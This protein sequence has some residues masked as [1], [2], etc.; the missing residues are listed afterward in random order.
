M[1]VQIADVVKPLFSV[2]KMKAAGN[3]GVFGSDEGDYIMNK[4]TGLKTKILDNGSDFTMRVRVPKGT[5]RQSER[6]VNM[7]GCYNGV[8]AEGCNHGGM[9]TAIAEDEE[10]TFQRQ[11]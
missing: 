6:G 11:P 4:A 5:T 8:C 10:E 1:G 9:W 3:V 7:V 2:R